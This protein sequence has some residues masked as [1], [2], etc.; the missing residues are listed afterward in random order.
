[1]LDMSERGP[2]RGAR[3]WRLRPT[4]PFALALNGAEVSFLFNTKP[5][6]GRLSARRAGQWPV[7]SLIRKP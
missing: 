6:S 3:H 5:H 4:D 7:S 1:M 2:D